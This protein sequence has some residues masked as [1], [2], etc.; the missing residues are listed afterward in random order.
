MRRYAGSTGRSAQ[1][2]S[3]ALF[4]NQREVLENNSGGGSGLWRKAENPALHHC[5]A[6]TDEER[7]AIINHTAMQENNSASLS[8]A[9]QSNLPSTSSAF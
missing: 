2:E 7:L 4:L 1:G 9:G 3:R 8:P 6:H 5:L